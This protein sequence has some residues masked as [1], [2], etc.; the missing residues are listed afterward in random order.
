MNK[1]MQIQLDQ[2]DLNNLLVDTKQNR[3]S[4]L[5]F[6]NHEFVDTD[7]SADLIDQAMQCTQIFT[8]TVFEA[9]QLRQSWQAEHAWDRKQQGVGNICED[10]GDRIPKARLLAVPD[11]TRCIRCQIIF[12]GRR[13]NI[14]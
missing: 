7:P 1:R 8:E 5:G 9:F 13:T 4:I 10:C 11:A 6:Q 14:R 2:P 3:V 12:E